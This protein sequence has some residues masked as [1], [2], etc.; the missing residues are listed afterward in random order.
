[1]YMYM[2]GE[3]DMSVNV[4]PAVN[5]L[6]SCLCMDNYTNFELFIYS[7]WFLSVLMNIL[8]SEKQHPARQEMSLECIIQVSES[9]VYMCICNVHTCT[10][11]CSHVHVH[12]YE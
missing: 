5:S 6:F 8:K 11:T 2:Y 7:Q 4:C 10:C 3:Q 1:M 9:L 12:V